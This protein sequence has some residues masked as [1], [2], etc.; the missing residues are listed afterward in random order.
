M[1][2][3]FL[4]LTT[5]VLIIYFLTSGGKTPFDYF[6]R[7][8]DSFLEGKYYLTDNPP[9]LNELI[10]GGNGKFYVAYP[11]MPGV[12]SIPFRFLFKDSFEQQYLA[13]IM[14]A[15]IVLLTMLISMKVKKDAKL[16]AWSGI[17]IGLG[18]IVWYLSSVGSSWYL[19]QISAAFFM[20]AAIYE[21]LGKKRVYLVG[22]FLGAAF[23]SRLHSILVLPLILYLLF[24]TEGASS[25][26]DWFKKLWLLGFGAS[27]FLLFNFFYNYIR[28]GVIWDKGY[29]LIPG[30]LDEPWFRKGLFNFSYIPDHLKVIFWSFPKVINKFPYLTPSWAGLAIWI[31][32]PA[33]IYS[34]FANLKERVVRLS[35]LS[36]LLISLVIFSHGTTGFAQFGYRFAVDF[37]PIL[38]FLTIKG[39]ARSGLRWHH[40]LL[41][42]VGIV[43]NLWGVILINKFGLVSF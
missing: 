39:V 33:F 31:T 21:S 17:L 42:L 25:K 1:K 28:F 24:N 20:T 37:Y 41:L 18:S 14:G 16:A 3:L 38:T 11:P 35:W 26:K 7:L 40:W 15:G 12:A 9:W 8:A 34:F 19:G 5:V 6:T 2:K 4:G 30:V 10:P 22:I 23:I 36:I 32:T 27:P 29:L 43:V 13:H